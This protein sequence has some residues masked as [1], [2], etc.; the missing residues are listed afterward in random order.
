[1]SK[2]NLEDTLPD[3]EDLTTVGNAAAQAKFEANNIK[4]QKE[5]FIANCVK[6]AYTVKE[7]QLNGKPPTQSY[8]ENTVKIV[9]NTQE[10][11]IKLKELNDQYREKWRIYEEAKT[12]LESMKDRISVFQ[13]L[14]SNK[15]SGF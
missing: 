15:R 12:L 5:S 2:R 9:G 11:A 13:T 1:M 3:W 8:I 7:Y 6:E 4:D 14:S 10:D